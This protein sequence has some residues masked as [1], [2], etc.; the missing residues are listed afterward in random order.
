MVRESQD[1]VT[2]SA[3][4][5][6]RKY[7]V[8]ADIALP[9]LSGVPGVLAVTPPKRVRLLATYFDTE[10]LRLRAAG[11]TLRHRKGGHDA[12]WHLK[13][14]AGGDREEIRVQA[15]AGTVPAGLAALVRSRT[16]SADLVPLAELATVRVVQR[17]IAEAAEPVVEIADDTVTG[18]RLPAGEVVVWR[19][20]EAELLAGPRK[21][22]DAVQEKLLA[23]GAA[24][25]RSSSKAGRVLGRALPRPT[26]RPWWSEP[27]GPG[28]DRSAA[29]VVQAHLAEQVEELLGRDPHARRDLPDAVH[30]MRVATRR[31]RSALVTFRPL[32]DSAVTDPLRD[33][34]RWL[35]GVLGEVRDAEVMRGRLLDM[36]GTEPPELVLGKVRDQLDLELQDRHRDAR[37]RL[38]AE[39]DGQRYLQLLD[40][41]DELVT[42][43]PFRKAARRAAEPAL[44]HAMRRSWRRLDRVMHEAAALPPGPEQQELLHEVRKDAKRARYAAESLGPA[45]GRP[46]RR[47][48]AQMEDLQE[49]LG[50]VQ[51]GVATRQ[52]LFELGQRSHL[53]GRNGF[54]L[55]RLHALEQ[56]RAEAT[57]G[58]WDEAQAVASRPKLR[59]WFKD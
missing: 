29:S 8:D 32:L 24:P 9:D 10:D 42:A 44:T 36:L 50:D 57:G 3:I 47:F 52:V 19:E 34:L 46:A 20:W 56:A 1:G 13:L 39:F 16:R 5:V 31:L 2:T 28:D 51:D 43:P 54:T 33:E 22:L 4:E 7:D 35:G 49:S 6:E 21:V 41:L 23:A 58:R 18:R 17:L 26:D 53:A 27:T 38:L 45:F 15:R 40:D 59:R 14:P 30:K 48:A 12:G 55:G 37:A 25:S 11:I